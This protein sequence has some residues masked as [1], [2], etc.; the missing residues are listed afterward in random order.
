MNGLLRFVLDT[1]DVRARAFRD[2][3]VVKCMPMLNP[4]GVWGGNW[5]VDSQNIDLN[6]YCM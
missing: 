3:F 4:D 1:K 2:T 6:R 5:R